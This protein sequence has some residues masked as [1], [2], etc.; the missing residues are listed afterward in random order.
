MRAEMGQNLFSHPFTSLPKTLHFSSRTFRLFDWPCHRS[1][2]TKL[3]ARIDHLRAGKNSRENCQYSRPWCPVPLVVFSCQEIR[4]KK[5]YMQV[6][7]GQRTG[8]IGERRVSALALCQIYLKKFGLRFGEG[9]TSVQTEAHDRQKRKAEDSR[10]KATSFKQPRHEGI[11]SLSLLCQVFD[12]IDAN[13]PVVSKAPSTLSIR[14]STLPIGPSRLPMGPSTLPIEQSRLPIGPS[15]SSSVPSILSALL[16]V[17]KTAAHVSS[18]VS[19]PR[20]FPLHKCIMCAA[21]F[22][23]FR[24]LLRHYWIRHQ[25]TQ[26]RSCREC[27]CGIDDASRKGKEAHFRRVHPGMICPVQGCGKIC[28]RVVLHMEQKHSD[29]CSVC[30]ERVG[31]SARHVHKPLVCPVGECR[32]SFASH[33]LWLTHHAE[34]HPVKDNVAELY[35]MMNL[36]DSLGLRNGPRKWPQVNG[37][38]KKCLADFMA[39]KEKGQK[40]FRADYF[41][42]EEGHTFQC[43]LCYDKAWLTKCRLAK[44]VRQHH[45]LLCPLCDLCFL[46]PRDTVMHVTTSHK[47]NICPEPGCDFLGSLKTG[48][49]RKK[50]KSRLRK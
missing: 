27:H 18:P 15:S 5:L 28:L 43:R 32:E 22:A 25:K 4:R 42:R 13:V 9:C 12:N 40:C 24:K 36:K 50:H 41:R 33:A 10:D 19:S 46:N 21:A 23:D 47:Q 29:T 17:G 2:D 31:D 48:H 26:L 11:D 16:S 20:P 3:T 38:R 30:L 6:L 14:R 37:M 39:A 49:Q 35:S 8:R 34:R 1:H 7:R 44:H 45:P